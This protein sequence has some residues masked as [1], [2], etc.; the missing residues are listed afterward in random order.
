MTDKNLTWIV[1]L[2][3]RS[4][5]M[6]SMKSDV[7]GGFAAFIEEQKKVDGA[8]A[9]T[10]AQFDDSY[11]VVYTDKPLNEVQELDLRPRGMTA[12][13]DSMGRVIT[14]T[15]SRIKALPKDSRP[16]SVIM[17]IMTDGLENSSREWT[18]DAIKSLVKKHTAKH[19]WQFLYMGANQDAIEE[20][21]KIGVSAANSMTYTADNAVGAMT[22]S[23]LNVAAYRS[24]RAAGNVFASVAYSDSQRKDATS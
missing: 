10:L 22:S 5:S 21:S 11:E 7:E 18:R 2:L 9:V 13:L 4:G 17:A 19:D 6:Q 23:G 12:L 14:D 24:A 20:G 8:C 1:F 3:D 15:K 16:G